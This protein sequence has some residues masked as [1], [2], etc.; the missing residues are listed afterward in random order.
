[1]QSGS[2]GDWIRL[3]REAKGWSQN[4]LAHEAGVAGTTV[5]RWERGITRPSIPELEAV[6]RA[7]GASEE[8][9]RQA[10]LLL[11]VRRAVKALEWVS[12]SGEEHLPYDRPPLLGDVIRAMRWRKGWSVADVAHALQTSERTVRAWE[13]SES[14]PSDELLHRLCFTLDA[15][16]EEVAILTSRKLHLVV[17]TPDAPLEERFAQSLDEMRYRLWH[18][19]SEGMDLGFLTLMAQAWWLAQRNPH[20]EFW[21]GTVL[22]MHCQWLLHQLRVKEAE[23]HAYPAWQVVRRQRAH[24]RDMSWIIQA[25][26]RGVM[27]DR[28]GQVVKPLE[29]AQILRDWLPH[30]RQWLEMEAWFL[31]SIAECLVVA[32]RDSEAIAISRSALQV[33]LRTEMPVEH[34]IAQSAHA[35]VLL[36]AG[37]P[38]E[39]LKHLSVSKEV[40][41]TVQVE[42]A[43]LWCRALL[44]VG[45]RQ[46]A[47]K[48]LQ[49]VQEIAQ[50]HHLRPYDER[51]QRLASNF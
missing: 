2:L 3:A 46:E 44:A 36:E 33:A 43:I 15:S 14:L 6:L 23:R 27:R 25:I 7:L 29:G 38:Q 21:L 48:W 31:R 20:G 18:G 8:Q 32:H 49:Q 26:A 35:F 12:A 10:L 24:A 16:T 41:P 40:H 34:H 28:A 50:R 47:L 39:A 13:H 9:R 19:E 37:Q 42:D 22:I 51:V 45:E 4:R 30:T 11:N 17:P 1:M 5:N